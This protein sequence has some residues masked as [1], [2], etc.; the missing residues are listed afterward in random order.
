MRNSEVIRRFAQNHPKQATG[1][2]M[3][4]WP[5]QNKLV[6]YCTAL[7]QR[8]PDGRVL[9]NM[10]SYS[11]TTSGH[12]ST[13]CSELSRAGIEP[14]LLDEIPRNETYLAQYM[15]THLYVPHDVRES[16]RREAW[17]ENQLAKQWQAITRAFK[18]KQFLI[19]VFAN[20]SCVKYNL[21]TGELINMRGKTT[22]SLAP[23]FRGQIL[24]D[25]IEMFPDDATRNYLRH[26]HEQTRRSRVVENNVSTFLQNLGEYANLEQYFAAGI[27]ELDGKINYS[28]S[29]VPKGLIEMARNWGLKISNR[30]VEQYKKYGD[31]LQNIARMEF[32]SLDVDGLLHLVLNSNNP[33]FNTLLDT[34][35]YN[36]AS[37]IRYL[38][39]LIS[40][41]QSSLP[42]LLTILKDYAGMMSALSQRF[43][44]YPKKLEEAHDVAVRN[45][46]AFKQ[47]HSEELFASRYDPRFEASIKQYEIIAPRQVQDIKDEGVAL[48]HCVAS[49]VDRVIQ[50]ETNI[51]F[52][53]S[54]DE[55]SQSLVTLEVSDG[56]VTQA[57]GKYNRVPTEQEQEVIS[58]YENKLRKER[59]A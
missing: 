32:T 42:Y 44:K 46:N 56:K 43:D 4:Y 48:H 28:L 54:K 17:R 58:R 50:G 30:A 19:F 31:I 27:T 35:S 36:Y 23:V 5:S 12:Q 34:H 2:H 11:R 24:S 51:L 22:N 29:E 33:D 26:V 57:R 55:P 41:S 52:L 16:R 13:L 38:D 3:Y 59:V 14:I 7:G 1:S 40:S 37:L 9:V 8:L 45:Y 15:D 25:V 39:G 21:S 10:T 20:D 53:R 47:E 18:D 49:Y 6:N